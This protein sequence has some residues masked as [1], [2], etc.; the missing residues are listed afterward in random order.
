MIAG[1]KSSPTMQKCLPIL[2]GVSD[3][4]ADPLGPAGGAGVRAL[5]RARVALASL[6]TPGASP[7]RCRIRRA[8]PRGLMAVV[9]RRYLRNTDAYMS[10]QPECV[11]S[12]RA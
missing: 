7:V 5:A 9:A 2:S 4:E 6:D 8:R 12:I 10:R 3:G 11:L 1:Y